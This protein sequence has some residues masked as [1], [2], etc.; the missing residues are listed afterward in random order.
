[1]K[2]EWIIGLIASSCILSTSAVA[3]VSS[4]DSNRSWHIINIPGIDAQVNLKNYFARL[5]N[6]GIG[7]LNRK[8]DKLNTGGVDRVLGE[9]GLPDLGSLSG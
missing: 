6:Y 7:V 3:S 5:K 2:R 1:M 9:L 4:D 8:I